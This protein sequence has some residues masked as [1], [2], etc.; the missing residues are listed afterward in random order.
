M[1]IEQ[2]IEALEKEIALQKEAAKKM[3]AALKASSEEAVICLATS[4]GLTQ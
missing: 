3:T 1:T 2:R 4:L